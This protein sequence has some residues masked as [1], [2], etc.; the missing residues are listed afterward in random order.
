MKFS[1]F[2]I[3]F[4]FS[5]S[6]SFCQVEILTTENFAENTKSGYWLI[7]FYADWCPHCKKLNPIF[8]EA[9]K[10]YSGGVTFG[11]VHCPDEGSVCNKQNIRGYPTVKL[12]ENGIEKT[13]FNAERTVES[14]RKFLI[15]EIQPVHQIKSFKDLEKEEVQFLLLIESSN[16]QKEQLIRNYQNS[17]LENFHFRKF[18]I[19]EYDSS[20]VLKE[21][22]FDAKIIEES[23]KSGGSLVIF[24]KDLF[25]TF[26]EIFY[27]PG[28][29][30]EL[31]DEGLFPPMSEL[32]RSYYQKLK[33]D[34]QTF[35][36]AILD[37]KH[38]DSELFKE[39]MITFSQTQKHLNF[40]W[41]DWENVENFFLNLPVK[42][43]DLP[44]III[45]TQPDHDLYIQPKDMGIANFFK[46]FSDGKL[47]KHQEDI[48]EKPEVF[49]SDDPQNSFE[50]SPFILLIVVGFFVGV[51]F[52]AY[53]LYNRKREER[54]KFD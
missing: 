13:T 6:F 48:Q 38:E 7:K 42:K 45:L 39:T 1:L 27:D 19:F 33:K 46:Q 14:F 20:D 26:E 32:S 34:K 11:S 47:K 53:K 8:E 18:S 5:I 40:V 51:G 21:T 24:Y 3:F 12:Y 31:I 2:S 4:L 23:I 37:R 28:N 15:N 10:K 29:L 25:E 49:F 54:E 50:F 36:L 44:T 35:A 17:A 52:M 22:D 9:A 30:E 16:S 41:I 43:Q